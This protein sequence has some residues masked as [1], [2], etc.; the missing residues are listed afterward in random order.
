MILLLWI[1]GCMLML[2]EC[3][4]SYNANCKCP[5]MK[6]MHRPKLSKIGS[7][8]LD[9]LSKYSTITQARPT[10]AKGNFK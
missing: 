9:I 6:R 2:N 8:L 1:G 5:P 7:E 10:E 3:V 4:S